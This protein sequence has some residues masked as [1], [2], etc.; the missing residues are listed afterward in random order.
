MPSIQQMCNEVRLRLDE[1]RPAKPPFRRVLQ[2]V[3]DATQTFYS[4]LENTGQAWSLKPDYSLVVTQNGNQDFQLSV[5]DSY[6]KPIQV[7]STYPQ[8]PSFI[9]RYIEFREF[10][11]MNF[12]WP[13]PVNFASWMLSD[14]SN[15]TAMRMAFYYKDDGSRWVRV[16]P[17][18]QLMATYAITFSS[19]DYTATVG[20]EQSPVLTQFHSIIETWA[21]LSILPSCEWWDDQKENR[22]HRREL[23][24]SLKNDESRIAEEFDGYC[25]NLV[26]DQIA[27]RH[28]SFDGSVDSGGWL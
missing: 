14:G 13:Y 2:A 9:P 4:R 24:A 22:E 6:G 18:P 8:N 23:A 27:I 20:M 17:Q 5:D 10:N 12:D 21:A 26:V 15:C 1:P 19:G 28:S 3:L 11:S 7:L 25:R 16:L